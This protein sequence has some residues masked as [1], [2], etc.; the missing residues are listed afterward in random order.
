MGL[1]EKIMT[2]LKAAMKAKDK[3]AL[4]GLRAIKQ[5]FLLAKTDGSGSEITATDEIKMMQKLVKQRNESIKIFRE[6]SRDDLADAEQEEVDVIMNYL[7][8]QMTEDDLKA[9]VR[10]KIEALGAS[11]MRDMGKVMGACSKE[12]AGQADGAVL[13]RIV[14]ELL[15]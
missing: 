6:Q 7:P 14:K 9:F 3:A 1:E 4:R 15:A 12:L 13:S 5:A 8:K 11:S 2:D 10:A